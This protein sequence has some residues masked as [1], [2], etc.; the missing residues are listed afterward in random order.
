MQGTVELR[1]ALGQVLV[2]D[3]DADVLTHGFWAG[4]LDRAADVE[5]FDPGEMSSQGDLG[6]FRAEPRA[7][8]PPIAPDERPELAEVVE[9]VGDGDQ[10]SAVSQYAVNP[11]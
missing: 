6:R 1:N 5:P 4:E 9:A 3:R 7:L 11:S 10:R 8:V 2:S